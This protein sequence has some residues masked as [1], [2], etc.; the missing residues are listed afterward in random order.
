MKR[1]LILL[2]SIFLIAGSPIQSVWA[3]E[4]SMVM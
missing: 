3:K 2:T 1:A 4:S